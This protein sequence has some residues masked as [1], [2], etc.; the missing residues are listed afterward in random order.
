[1]PKDIKL[2]VKIKNY[3]KAY[4]PNCDADIHAMGQIDNCPYCGQAVKWLDGDKIEMYGVEKIETDGK[5]KVLECF[6]MDLASGD[7]YQGTTIYRNGVID[8]GKV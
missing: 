6:G 1:M 2:P 8:N 5:K 3:G 4:C 7:D